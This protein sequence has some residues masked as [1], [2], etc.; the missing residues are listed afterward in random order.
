MQNQPTER[1]RA[2]STKRS[3]RESDGA[4]K[5]HSERSHSSSQRLKTPLTFK[6]G[7]KDRYGLDD[8]EVLARLG[9]GA[10]GSVFLVQLKAGNEEIKELEGMQFAMKVQE[11]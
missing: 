1:R 11:K 8:F 2:N 5:A 6:T 9:A 4:S 3:R 10:F 7:T